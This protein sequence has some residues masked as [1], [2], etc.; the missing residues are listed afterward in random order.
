MLAPNWHYPPRMTPYIDVDVRDTD[1]YHTEYFVIPPELP[2]FQ[3]RRPA[4]QRAGRFGR[5]STAIIAV[6]LIVVLPLLVL[7][8]TVTLHNVRTEPRQAIS[9]VEREIREGALRPSERP[10][11]SLPVYQRAAAD[12]FR[13]TRGALVM[14]PERLVYVGLLPRDVFAA[15]RDADIFERA[16]FPLDT[17]TTIRPT[18]AILA[19]ARAI[20]IGREGETITL[21]VPRESWTLAESLL[22]AVDERHAAARAEAARIRAEL[23]AAEE[24]ARRPLYH[25]IARGEALSTIATRYGITVERIQELNGMTDTR[26]KVGQSLLVKPDER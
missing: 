19:T 12:Y 18:R 26:I 7:L 11:H 23:L 24:A 10:L 8:G 5:H 15:G 22:A 4:A 14:T 2:R 1:P 20:E 3:Q 9:L 16:A 17:L 21:V 13:R 6:A 25:T